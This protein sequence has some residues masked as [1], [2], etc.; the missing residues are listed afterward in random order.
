M[1][2]WLRMKR[3]RRERKAERDAIRRSEQSLRRA[4]DEPERE[5]DAIQEN[6][7]RGPKL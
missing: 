5:V 4:G 2:L 7:I 3:W 6:T 1:S